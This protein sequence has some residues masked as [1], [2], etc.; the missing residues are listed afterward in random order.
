MSLEENSYAEA[1]CSFANLFCFSD[2]KDESCN[3]TILCKIHA[4]IIH[5]PSNRKYLN[6]QLKIMNYPHSLKGINMEIKC[7]RMISHNDSA[8][9]SQSS[10][11]ML[12]NYF[13]KLC[14]SGVEYER[15]NNDGVMYLHIASFLRARQHVFNRSVVI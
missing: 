10:I 6:L 2:F 14:T 13:F 9:F 7:L 12:Y 1:V 15:N 5:F 8:F 3:N 4:V 11:L